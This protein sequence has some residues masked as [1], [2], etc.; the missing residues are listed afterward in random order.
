MTVIKRNVDGG[1]MDATALD[2]SSILQLPGSH[3]VYRSRSV[4]S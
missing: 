2:G 3:G 4:S 1:W